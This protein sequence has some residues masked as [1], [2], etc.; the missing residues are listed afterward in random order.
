ML[1]TAITILDTQ[2]KPVAGPIE[3]SKNE[4]QWSLTP[5][6]MWKAGSYT[7]QID[8][9]LEDNAGNSIEKQFDVDVFEKT[10]SP[11]TNST[12]ITFTVDHVNS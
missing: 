7:I 4:S 8:S 1:Q 11:K 5:K 6:A 3:I 10:Q 2:S 12:K 9:R